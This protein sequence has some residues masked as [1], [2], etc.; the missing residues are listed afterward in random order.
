M[1]CT[2]DVLDLYL[3]RRYNGAKPEIN[4]GYASDKSKLH[5]RYTYNIHIHIH[6]SEICLTYALRLVLACFGSFGLISLDW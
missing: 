6:M 2:L 3:K 5:R 4:M 1:R